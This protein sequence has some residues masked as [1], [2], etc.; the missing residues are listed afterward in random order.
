MVTSRGRLGFRDSFFFLTYGGQ[1]GPTLFAIVARRLG[2]F[3]R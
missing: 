2:S 3:P 1:P